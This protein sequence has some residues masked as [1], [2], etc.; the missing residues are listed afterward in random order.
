MDKQHDIYDLITEESENEPQKEVKK[1][2]IQEPPPEE[3]LN[4]LME[5]VI[6]NFESRKRP[7][8]DSNECQGCDYDSVGEGLTTGSYRPKKT[9]IYCTMNA[10]QRNR[11]YMRAVRTGKI[12][13]G[14]KYTE[15]ESDQYRAMYGE[16]REKG[17]PTYNCSFCERVM[18]SGES[19]LLSSSCNR[20]S[21]CPTCTSFILR[22]TKTKDRQCK[23]VLV[24]RYTQNGE[25]VWRSM[26]N[27][28]C[29]NAY[30]DLTKPS[31]CSWRNG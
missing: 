25:C 17:E 26:F 19:R 10:L 7:H 15:L 29:I 22:Y 21:Y 18:I 3:H 9:D 24:R 23:K 31:S 16:M 14:D 13:K 20:H 5:R 11:R 28:R 30:K 2:P 1:F 4:A 27:F 8:D 6:A 12:M